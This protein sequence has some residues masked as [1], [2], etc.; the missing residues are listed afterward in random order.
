MRNE[1]LTLGKR[2]PVPTVSHP[3]SCWMSICHVKR[4]LFLT[5][6][7]PSGFHQQRQSSPG[8]H[9]RG[10]HQVLV[11]KMILKKIL[12]GNFYSLIGGTFFGEGGGEL[13]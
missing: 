2:V 1:S 9:L 10:V 11:V 12:W 5:G 8:S 7:L 6:R 13:L 4:F 3:G